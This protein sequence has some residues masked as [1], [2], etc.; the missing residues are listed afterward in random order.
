MSDHI[1]VTVEGIRT[2]SYMRTLGIGLDASNYPVL[3]MGNFPL[4]RATVEV[5]RVFLLRVVRKSYLQQLVNSPYKY[6]NGKIQLSNGRISSI[7]YR[8]IDA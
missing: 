2:G 4:Y 1:L 3:S 8:Q 6:L 7:L 5:P